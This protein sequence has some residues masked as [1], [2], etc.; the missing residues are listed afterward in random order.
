MNPNKKVNSSYEV[1]TYNGQT[2]STNTMTR[3]QAMAINP[4]S[5]HY[6]L[7]CALG[8][9]GF[10]AADGNWVEHRGSDWPGLGQ[11]GIRMIQAL[12]LNPAE[13]LTPTEIADITGRSRLG[14]N[15]AL[16]ARL[17][18]LRKAHGESFKKP[19]FF[20]SR[21]DGGFAIAWN[22][23]STWMWVER[24]TPTTVVAE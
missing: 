7:S 6:F 3:E 19:H 4:Q 20:L 18:A 16:S 8:I 22:P 12:Q 5:V 11:V 23:Q 1:T 10:R 9:W 15:K 21:R 17:M 2:T 14:D 13:F 24:I